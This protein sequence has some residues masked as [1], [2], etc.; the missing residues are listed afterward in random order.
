M[1]HVAHARGLC[2]FHLEML[3]WTFL[4]EVPGL[5]IAHVFRH[6]N[7]I[8]YCWVSHGFGVQ[9]SEDLGR[10][11]ALFLFESQLGG[12]FRPPPPPR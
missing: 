9:M 4:S 7:V 3:Y 1:G 12:F 2:R 6:C 10:T 8:R 11:G 5:S